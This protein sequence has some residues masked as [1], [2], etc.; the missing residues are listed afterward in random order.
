MRR[1]ASVSQ[2]LAD[3]SVPWE[4]RIT[5]AL[6]MRVMDGSSSF[7]MGEGETS[8]QDEREGSAHRCGVILIIGGWAPAFRDGPKRLLH[9]TAAGQPPLQ[10]VDARLRAPQGTRAVGALEA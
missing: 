10:G 3:S 1:G 4:A 6:S 8:L 5:R 2:L 9:V 7:R